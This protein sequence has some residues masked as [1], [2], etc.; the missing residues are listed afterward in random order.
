MNCYINDL[1]FQPEQNITDR[2][3]L[4]E[5]FSKVCNLAKDFTFG[6]IFVP[7][8]YM[9]RPIARGITFEVLINTADRNISSRLKSIRSHQFKKITSDNSVDN[10]ISFSHKGQASEFLT[11]ACYWGAP[12]ISFLTA[13]K[14]NKCTLELQCLSDSN[15]GLKSV[16]NLGCFQHFEEHKEYLKEIVQREYEDCKWNPLETPFRRKELCQNYLKSFQYKDKLKT[17][18]KRTKMA[19]FL[20]VGTHIAELNGWI[21]EKRLSELNS[22]KGKKR[23]IF[24]GGNPTCYLSIDVMHGCFEFLDRQGKHITEYSFEAEDQHKHY[25]DSSHDINV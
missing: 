12:V 25:N 16:R 20:E 22:A 5:T 8:D 6:G 7:E 21:Y 15:V 10:L 23:K 2:E 3:S 1:S 17:C 19:M 18:D 9:Y 4:A 11:R 14:W 24:K 13:E